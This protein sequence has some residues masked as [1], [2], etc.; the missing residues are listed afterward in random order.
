MVSIF[1]AIESSRK[2]ESYFFN[3]VLHSYSYFT[4][5]YKGSKGK[6]SRTTQICFRFQPKICKKLLP[7]MRAVFNTLCS[8]LFLFLSG[9]FSCINQVE[10]LSVFFEYLN[11]A[12]Y[13]Q[14]VKSSA[15]HLLDI[16]VHYSL[17]RDCSTYDHREQ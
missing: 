6:P 5:C 10:V 9:R 7:F 15:V 2:L 17:C 1:L 4:P 16:V 11:T 14:P 8:M 13:L 12:F 3:C